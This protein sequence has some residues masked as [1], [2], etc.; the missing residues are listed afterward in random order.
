MFW[1]WSSPTIF[2]STYPNWGRELNSEDEDIESMFDLQIDLPNIDDLF[3]PS[4]ELE[5]I[6]TVEEINLILILNLTSKIFLI[7]DGSN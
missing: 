7:S 3:P 4:D 6:E 5:L 1:S 2:V